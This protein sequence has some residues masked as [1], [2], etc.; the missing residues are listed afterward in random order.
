MAQCDDCGFYRMRGQAGECRCDPPSAQ[1][2]IGV[3]PQ[4]K[5]DDWCGK[6]TAITATREERM[7]GEVPL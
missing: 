7:L 4:V 3:W 5:P 2:A 1:G 6:W